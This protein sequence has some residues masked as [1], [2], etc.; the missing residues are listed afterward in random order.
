MRIERQ[1]QDLLDT[2]ANL[3]KDNDSLKE[4]N[5]DLSQ[6]L[7]LEK[8]KTK[9]L[10]RQNKTLQDPEVALDGLDEERLFQQEARLDFQVS[11][12]G[13][14][15]LKVRSSRTGMELH[16]GDKGEH[17]LQQGVRK[18]LGRTKCQAGA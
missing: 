8:A 18:T 4:K 1:L 11:L 9:E 14:R 6:L 15:I 13:D 3:R 16:T 10:V 7:K 2:L 12:D 17:I 5:K